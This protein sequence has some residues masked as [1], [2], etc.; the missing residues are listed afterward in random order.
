MNS[1]LCIIH[2]QRDK[3]FAAA[4]DSFQC[5][6]VDVNGST[7]DEELLAR[8][9]NIEWTDTI[10]RTLEISTLVDPHLATVFCDVEEIFEPKYPLPGVDYEVFPYRYDACGNYNGTYYP[11]GHT[12]D[13]YYD[14]I[15]N[16]P[17]Y[18][19]VGPTGSSHSLTILPIVVWM[20]VVAVLYLF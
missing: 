17:Y 8:A 13:Y 20:L 7:T 9:S 4:L 11:G 15:T 10:S 14:C 6:N 2:N 19:P 16:E 1:S 5:N 3:T 18:D 12:A